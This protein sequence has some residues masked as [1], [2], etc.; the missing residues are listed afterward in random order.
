[1][2]G[3]PAG[4]RQAEAGVLLR[5]GGSAA[6]EGPLDRVARHRAPRQEFLH[7][8][9]VAHRAIERRHRKLGHC[10]VPDHPVESEGVFLARQ[11]YGKRHPVVRS[12]EL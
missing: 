11:V 2:M 3:Q 7:L 4:A 6:C 10:D 1:M 8:A 5:A 12:P 9:G